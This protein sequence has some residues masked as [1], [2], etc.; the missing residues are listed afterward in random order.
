MLYC[1][2]P[3]LAYYSNLSSFS[4]PPTSAFRSTIVNMSDVT[5]IDAKGHLF[6]RL[7]SITAKQ[8][9]LGKKIVIVRC[10]AMVIS[11]SLTRNKVKFAQFINKRMNTNPRR[12]PYHFRSPARLFWR[13]LRGMLPHK[14][15]RG[16]LALG[17]LAT[18]EG[19]PEPYDK[20]KR[21]VVPAALKAVRMRADRNFCLLGALSKEVG[22]GYTDLVNSLEAQRKLKEQAFYQE[23]KQLAFRQK[24]ARESAKV[25]PKVTSVLAA[26]GY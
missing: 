2:N 3:S 1:Q 18:Y 20:V 7:A 23:K 24:K 25:D 15:A 4:F 11:G 12:G 19:I 14:T 17:R 10:E 22:W 13:S 21:V 26:A 9:L 5:V 8:L 6:G 16:Q